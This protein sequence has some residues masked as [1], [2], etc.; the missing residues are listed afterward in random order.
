[1]RAVAADQGDELPATVL[2]ILHARLMSLP[3][4][5]RRIL[6]TASVFG[7]TCWAGGVRRLLGRERSGEQFDSW[8]KILVEAE[9]LDR[10]KESRFAGEV[11]YVF[12]HG[13]LREAA[14]GMLPDDERRLGHYLA[15]CYLE[16]LVARHPQE[17]PEPA[18]RDSYLVRAEL[19]GGAAPLF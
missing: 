9:L 14:Y 1:M 8:L 10:C 12:R 17:L 19:H 11:E 18:P 16:E 6:R 7:Q 5:A 13:L 15:G 2:A 3:P 4:E